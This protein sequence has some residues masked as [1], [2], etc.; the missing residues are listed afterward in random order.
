VLSTAGA[1]G[2]DA[3]PWEAGRAEAW[4]TTNPKLTRKMA[5]NTGSSISG[6]FNLIMQNLLNLKWA[7]VY[8]WDKY[9]IRKMRDLGY[10]PQVF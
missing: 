8:G 9:P 2:V 1:V 10:L 6:F 7:D 4:L 3:A 5:R